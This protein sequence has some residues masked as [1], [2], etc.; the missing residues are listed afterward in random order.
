MTWGLK[1]LDSSMTDFDQNICLSVTINGAATM[2]SA[3]IRAF[4]LSKQSALNMAL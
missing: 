2:K 4:A 1:L 3:S